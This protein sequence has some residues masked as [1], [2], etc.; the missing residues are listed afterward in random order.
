MEEQSPANKEFH[1]IRKLTEPRQTQQSASEESDSIHEESESAREDLE[2]LHDEW[3]THHVLTIEIALHILLL[4]SIALRFC[5]MVASPS[6]QSKCVHVASILWL[7]DM[8]VT[9]RRVFYPRLLIL[10]ILTVK[11]SVLSESLTGFFND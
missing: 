8:V 10:V 7:C 1:K 9:T 2:K 3:L 6:I 4:T 5:E 11:S